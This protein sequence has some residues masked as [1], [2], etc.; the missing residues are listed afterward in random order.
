[1]KRK[2]LNKSFLKQTALAVPAA[3]LMLGAAQAGT[4]VGLNF[5]AWYYDSGTTPQTI[6]FG[7][8]YQTT[9]FPVT[10]KAFGVAPANWVNTEP[11]NCS[12]AV[13]TSVTLGSVTVNLTAVNPW[14][15]EIGNL[16][17]PTDEW[18]NT[19]PLQVST[20]SVLPGNDEVTW[21]F[22]DNTGWTNSLAG[23]NTAFSNGYVIELIGA[24]KCTANSRVVVMDGAT[25]TT[26]AFDL[27]Y[28]AGNANF[29]GPVGLLA[30][31]GTN[32]TITFGA[33]T[34]NISSAESCALAGF[35]ITDKPVVTKDPANTTVNQGATLNLTATVIGVGALSY[36]WQHAGTNFPGAT[37]A[38]YSNPSMTAED[39]GSYDLVVTN[40]YGATT[41]G[42]ATVSVVQV[43]AITKDL[44]GIS[45]T[46]FAGANFS[47]W[48]VVA[49]GAQPLHYNWF[50]G[51]T[52]A[53]SDSPTLTLINV[54]VADSGDYHVTVSN[55]IGSAKSATNHLT[56]VASPDM[57]TTDVAQDAP[58]AYWPLGETSGTIANDY[59]GAAHSGTNNG[60][61]TLGA[62]GPRPPSY[63]GFNAGKLAYQFD[64]SSAYIDCGTGPSLS[65]ITDF[66]LEAWVNTTATAAGRIV[67]QRYANGYNGEYMLGLN[68][69]GTVS[70]GLYGGGAYQF[71]MNSPNTINDGK[72]HYVAAVRRNGT[73]GVIYIDGTAAVYQNVPFIAP[74]DNTFPTYIGA[75]MRD[76]VSYFN[77]SISDVAIYSYA[78][79]ASR[80]GLHAYNGRYGDSPI[81]LS[82][83]PGGYSIDSKPV[84]AP[85]A[86]ANY[87][88]EW[89]ASVTDTAPS[90]VT[91]TGVV[92]FPGG[93]QVAIPTNADFNSS[94]G[95][96]CFWMLTG[97]PTKGNGSILFDRRTT[98]GLVF[99]LDGTPSGGIDV[100]YTGGAS[101]AAGGYVVDG[102]WH[103]VALT[104]DQSASGSVTVYVD[105]AQVGNEANTSAWSWD[106]NQQIELGRSHDP[107]W[108]AYNGEMDDFR[109]Y[110]RVLTDTEIATIAA[111]ATSDTLVDTAALKVR[112]NFDTAG[113]GKSLV[114]PAGSLLTSPTLGPAAVWTPVPGAGSPYPFLPPPPAI[115]AGTTMFYRI[116]L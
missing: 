111:P 28:T 50:K 95:T 103:H 105:G 116:G 37:N 92:Q 115:P 114:W 12:A 75:D 66:T 88:T 78:L 35:I 6:G 39:A 97:I 68:A 112:Y 26:N 102:Y 71:N 4:T 51:S 90:P 44:A 31:A 53:G 24:V 93:A 79:S 56:V 83:I 58:G 57:Y 69:D 17:N 72:W 13:A 48:S 1:M 34:R 81:V 107:Y 52:P 14:S 3:A 33:V 54:S 19:G 67:Q 36:Q 55:A 64:G 25:T 100:Q 98:A 110:S 109:I 30:I 46:I 86:G 61:L 27:V 45:G 2:L 22:E 89:L 47:A 84:G 106:A 62:T 23:L 85:H 43:P 113:G 70:F 11:L 5:Q 8:G 91:R 60:G 18:T 76:K 20:S 32:D 63:Q 87:G 73:N 49:G 59:S 38:T 99:F 74:L 21:G 9:G 10:T 77:G 40:L 108:Q 7:Q 104:Y 80:I 42:V 16:V 15:G 29:P 94:A 96:I 65:G 82:V 41:S 101:F